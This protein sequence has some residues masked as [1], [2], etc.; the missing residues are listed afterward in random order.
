VL[1]GNLRAEPWDSG[2]AVAD[3]LF[4]VA[5][6]LPTLQA[7]IA[8]DDE[9][10]PHG[11]STPVYRLGEILAN[12]SGDGDYVWRRFPFNHPLFILFSS[13]TTGAPKCIVHGA[14]GTL[15]EHV[16][17]HRLHCDLR[18]GDRLFFQ[19]SCAWM[20]WNWQLT[21]LASETELVLY[22]GPVKSPE[23][24][25]RIVADEGVTVFGTS[26]A[27][28]Q[29]CERTGFAPGQSLELAALRGVL[30]TGSILYSRQYD[31]VR[32]HVKELPLQSISGGTDIIGCFV[33]G[34][35]NLP[36]H[37]G[38]A[39]CRSL[40]LD[41]RSLPPADAPNAAIG[42]LICANPFPSR[43]SDFMVMTTASAS[44]PPTSARIR[45]S[46]PMAI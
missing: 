11:L 45:G 34:N 7:I 23:A 4:E 36:V 13:G 20:M 28:L 44:T 14:G 18:R 27:Y 33:L 19:T 10:P 17:E 21:A 3:R 31:W 15:L 25:W 12:N 26:P 5:R 24:L 39:Q 37:R 46:G 43:P 32:A 30:S 40:G 6:R 1:M 29:F 9:T 16:K 35:P 41:V 8:F 22:D 42:E 2:A 38:E